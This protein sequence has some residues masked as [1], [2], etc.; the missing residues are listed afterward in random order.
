MH[1]LFLLSLSLVQIIY[2]PLGLDKCHGIRID[3]LAFFAF[4]LFIKCAISFVFECILPGLHRLLECT[5]GLLLYMVKIS[6]YS[7]SLG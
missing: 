7:S 1:P 5:L 4:A 6:N 2:F 3:V